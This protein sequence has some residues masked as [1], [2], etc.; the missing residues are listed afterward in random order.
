MYIVA[1]AWLYVV[2]M[3]SIT[4]RSAVA[5]VMTFLLYGALP[6]TIVLYLMDTPR[7]KRNRQLA[8]KNETIAL[9]P[10]ALAAPDTDEASTGSDDP[11]ELSP[12]D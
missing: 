3:M 2:F 8:K 7:R 1:I 6:L 12:H 11:H 5:G 9:Q 10:A 4:E